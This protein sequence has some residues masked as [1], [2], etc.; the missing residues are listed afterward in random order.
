MNKVLVIAPHP[1]DETF[2]C[3]GTILKHKEFGDEIY[4]LIITDVNEQ[5]GRSQCNSGTIKSVSNYYGFDDTFELSLSD[6]KID[7]YSMD[8]LVSKISKV[9]N[10]VKPNIVY[11]PFYSDVHS[12]HRKVFE[13]CYSCVK[14]FRY[15]FIEKVLMMEV[16]SETELGLHSFKP[17]YFVDISKYIYKKEDIIKLYGD[18]IK[19]HPFP[20]SIENI[21]ALATFRGAMVNCKYAESFMVLKEIWGS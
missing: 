19:E 1:D 7:E 16:L 14:S 3:G 4:W 17:N 5:W 2:G 12:D 10:D 15:P 11:L 18:E 21:R 6:A 13:A 8:E 9:F 20:R